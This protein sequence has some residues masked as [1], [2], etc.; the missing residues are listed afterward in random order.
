MFT[1]QQK[2]TRSFAE[3][4]VT[5]KGDLAEEQDT[6]GRRCLFAL[7]YRRT[8]EELVVLEIYLDDRPAVV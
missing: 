7:L 8:I 6:L 5:V 1:A 2:K 4:F 3:P